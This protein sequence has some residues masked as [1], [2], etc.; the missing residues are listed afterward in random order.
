LD[1]FLIGY[2]VQLKSFKLHW[3]ADLPVTISAQVIA[4]LQR[5]SKYQVEREQNGSGRSLEW[6]RSGERTLLIKLS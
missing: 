1:W 3:I 2:P 5:G 4:K 6:E